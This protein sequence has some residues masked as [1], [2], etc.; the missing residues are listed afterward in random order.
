MLTPSP[1]LQKL[2]ADAGFGSRREIERWIAAGRIKLNGNIAQLGERAAEDAVIL[3]D[4]QKIWPQQVSK[5]EL[6]STVWMYHKPSGEICTRHDPEQRPTVFDHLPKLTQQRWISIGRLDFNTSGL[7]LFTTDGELAQKLMHPSNEIVRV[8]EVRVYG[9][10]S[11]E[12][13]AKLRKGVRLT[14]GMAKFLSLEHIRG[15]GANHWYRATLA[16]G[17]NREVRRLWESQDVSVNR[18]VRV[19]FGPVSLPKDLLLRE[20]KFLSPALTKQLDQL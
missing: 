11:E 14:D 4:N 10:V 7:L 6:P 15:E 17:R 18:L 16:E 2:L 19:A 9:R 8:Y 5:S 20:G 1:K 13:I 12:I 3:L